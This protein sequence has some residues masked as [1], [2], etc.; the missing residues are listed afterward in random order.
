[1]TQ[2]YWLD[3]WE[4]NETGFHLETFN[5]YL[6]E[7]WPVL[8]LA[9]GSTVFV[10][11]CGKTRDM[12]WLRDQGHDV[13]GVELSALAVQAFYQENAL[14]PALEQLPNG[15]F[16]CYSAANI[17]ILHGDFFD[18]NKTDLTGIH[19][20]YD[21]ASLVALPPDI[22]RRYVARMIDILPPATQ[23]LL[24]G[25]DYPQ[26]EMQGPPYAVPPEEVTA[27][28]Q[29][30]ADVRLLAQIDVLADSPR[31][32]QRGLTRLIESVY[33]LTLHHPERS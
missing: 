4:R 26:A 2:L 7:F 29:P 14:V 27:L 3:R 8:R 30:D 1:M 6:V 17:N 13:L 21:R 25:F 24:V 12:V 15:L 28:Y 18:L 31:F 23:I 11:L 9:A 20:V 10:P 32:Q 19:A 33:L 5:P 22:R 16:N